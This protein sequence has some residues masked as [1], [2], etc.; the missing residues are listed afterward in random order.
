MHVLHMDKGFV[1][2][3][4]VHSDRQLCKTHGACVCDYTLPVNANGL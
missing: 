1:R 2:T 3:Q 4:G